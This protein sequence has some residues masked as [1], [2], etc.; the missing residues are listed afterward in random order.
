MDDRAQFVGVGVFGADEVGFGEVVGAVGGDDP[1]ALLR[2]AV[3]GDL[4]KVFLG[5]ESG[6][7]HQ[8]LVDRAQLV[9][10]EF[11]VGD[12][13]AVGSL[14]AL[15]FL[16]EQ[17]VLQ[18]VLDLLVAEADLVDEMGRRRG[19]EVRAKRIEF[20]AGCR[21]VRIELTN[22]WGVAELA[23]V[24]QLLQRLV[25]VGA[26]AGAHGR[27]FGEGQLAQA[28]EPVTL[29][30]FGCAGG[31]YLHFRGGFRVQQEQDA[32]QEPQR[33]LG[34]FL[35]V[36]TVH[37]QAPGPA[38]IHHIVG[39]DLDGQPDALAQVLGD[40]DRVLD[41]ILEDTGPP[42]IAVGIGFQRLIPEDRC[43]PVDF[44]AARLVLALGHHQQVDGEISAL[45]PAFGL[46]Q[47]HPLPGLHDHEG[48]L[49]FLV[50]SERRR[51]RLGDRFDR[52][53]VL[54]GRSDQQPF[55]RIEQILERRH[56]IG[57][58][59]EHIR[60]AG[61]LR[62]GYHQLGPGAFGDEGRELAQIPQGGADLGVRLGR[63]LRVLGE[64]GQIGL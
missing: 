1:G 42:D 29:L 25:Q 62:V 50:G 47:Q 54:G 55:V 21:V 52:L 9:D 31:Q 18:H 2:V 15:A 41:R 63:A 30:V 23:E 64:G 48:G 46:G 36:D 22:L 58:Q 17:Q 28:I 53:P 39:D 27:Q 16:G 56:R 19:E 6:V 14:A 44:A 43:R 10:A 4:E 26:G 37:R 5:E 7:G 3:L 51:H 8:A 45:G 34:Q 12:E 49:S 60:D 20:E 40:A 57:L 33:V 59:K 61:Q 13:A 38:A 24:E 11:G 35:A 32:V